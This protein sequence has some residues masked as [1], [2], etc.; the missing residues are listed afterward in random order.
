MH[1]TYVETCFY[2]LLDTS[3]RFL[4]RQVPPSQHLC[5]IFKGTDVG[6]YQVGRDIGFTNI[7]LERLPLD[8]QMWRCRHLELWRQADECTWYIHSLQMPG[9]PEHQ[10]H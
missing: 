10:G 3:L 2:H 4:L 7:W 9:I 5:L 6:E 1:W 8:L